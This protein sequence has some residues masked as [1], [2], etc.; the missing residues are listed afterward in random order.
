MI[1]PI[2][3]RVNVK[4]FHLEHADILFLTHKGAPFA[5]LVMRTITTL[6]QEWAPFYIACNRTSIT[7]GPYSFY[8]RTT[9][10]PQLR[11]VRIDRSPVI[12]RVDSVWHRAKTEA[13]PNKIAWVVNYYGWG[14]AENFLFR[15]FVCGWRQ[16]TR[17]V[18]VAASGA[19]LDTL[20]ETQVVAW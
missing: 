20:D 8:D 10:C 7:T 4:Y 1:P 13:C 19:R 9:V 14:C 5:R 3:V 2:S 15:I 18:P 6:S 17:F 12:S 16:T 11:S